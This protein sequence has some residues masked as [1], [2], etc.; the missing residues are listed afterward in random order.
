MRHYA[1]YD[2]KTGNIVQ[3]HV[4]V[5]VGGRSKSLSDE[6]VLAILPPHFQR[7]TV[8]VVSFDMKRETGKHLHLDPKTRQ[9]SMVPVPKKTTP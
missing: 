3:T 9:V 7:D 8:G 5:D 4:E 6:E 1:I 2:L